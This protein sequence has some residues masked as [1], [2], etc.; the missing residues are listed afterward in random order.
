LRYSGGDASAVGHTFTGVIVH[1]DRCYLIWELFPVVGKPSKGRTGCVTSCHIVS[2][3]GRVIVSVI[4]PLQQNLI[5]SLVHD[6]RRDPRSTL[7]SIF[8]DAGITN[9][10]ALSR[11]GPRFA[12]ITRA[13]FVCAS[14]RPVVNNIGD[15]M[16]FDLSWKSSWARQS[17]LS[18]CYLHP[19]MSNDGFSRLDPRLVKRRACKMLNRSYLSWMYPEGEFEGFEF[20]RNYF[21]YVLSFNYKKI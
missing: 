14:R 12:F 1:S 16:R 7:G 6:R 19:T 8:L 3:L 11:R 15:T 9:D 10:L 20:S 18:R 2:P 5:R 21:I 17:L 13:K 4:V